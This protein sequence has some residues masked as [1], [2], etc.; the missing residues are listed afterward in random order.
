MNLTALSQRYLATASDALD[1][2]RQ[3]TTTV[4]PQAQQ[5]VAEAARLAQNFTDPNL[6]PEGLEA[7]RRELAQQARQLGATLAD[8]LGREVQRAALVARDAADRHTAAGDTNEQLLAELRLSRAWER[9]RAQLDAGAALSEVIES[10]DVD[11]LRA[12]RT[13]YPA[14]LRAQDKR[15]GLDRAQGDQT[16]PTAA[17]RAVDEALVPLLPGEAGKALAAKLATDSALT[18]TQQALDG[19]R[20]TGS[21]S[22]SPQNTIAAAYAANDAARATAPAAA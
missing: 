21:G 17:I 18:A 20:L 1:H 12:L 14:Y 2:A 9:A 4:L 13:E 19:M 22:A 8:A 5:Q 15:R 7:R 6:S 11:T 10:A 3:I 16:D